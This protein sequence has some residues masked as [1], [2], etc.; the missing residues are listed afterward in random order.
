PRFA[1]TRARLP[2]APPPAWR[3]STRGTA[4]TATLVVEGFDGRLDPP[5][6]FFPRAREVIEHA[7]PQ[8]V[9]PIVDGFRL[10]LTRLVN[11][12]G[13]VAPLDGVLTVGGR[14]FVVTAPIAITGPSV[15]APLAL[16]FLGGLLLNLMPCVFPVLALKA[17]GLVGLAGE[18]RRD[19]RVHGLVYA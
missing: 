19:A 12:T 15:A 4:D 10:E 1:A 11:A 8:R 9:V 14:S 2:T 16:A 3:L 18:S 6:L 7:A 5:P 17:L 13:D